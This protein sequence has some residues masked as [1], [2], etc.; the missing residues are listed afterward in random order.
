MQRRRYFS[1]RNNN[2]C[3]RN[4]FIVHLSQFLSSSLAAGFD[5]ILTVDRNEHMVKGK[6]A[7]RLKAL[8]LKEAYCEKFDLHGG[9]ASFSRGQHQIDG[10]WYSSNIVPTSVS[11]CPFEF[12]TG[13]Y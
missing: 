10:V 1:A 5:I 12:G 9:P 4:L 13:D 6:L 8:G 2:E 7:Q 11:L 3:P